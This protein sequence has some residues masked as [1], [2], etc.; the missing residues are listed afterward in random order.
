MTDKLTEEQLNARIEQLKKIVKENIIKETRVE[1]GY[2][3]IYNTKEAQNK[4][5]KNR[6]RNKAQKASRK[7]N[8]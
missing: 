6:N 7:K 4:K 3:D 8:R 2:N 5:Q 1:F